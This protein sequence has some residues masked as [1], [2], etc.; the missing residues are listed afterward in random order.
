MSTYLAIGVA[1][2]VWICDGGCDPL[3]EDFKDAALMVLLWLPV[4]GLMVAGLALA[5][6]FSAV[7][8]WIDRVCQIGRK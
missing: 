8:A 3:G 5:A 6:A 1:F 4:G 7:S 2:V